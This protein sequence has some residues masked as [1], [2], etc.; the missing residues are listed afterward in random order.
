MTCSASSH[1]AGALLAAAAALVPA[2]EVGAQ[3]WRFAVSPYLWFPGTDVSVA[4]PQGDVD[5]SISVGDALSDLDFALMGTFEAQSWPWS[6]IGDLVYTDLTVREP[7]PFGVLFSRAD[8]RTRLG[9][10]TGYALYRAYDDGALALDVGAGLR[11]VF[12]DIDTRLRPA[13]A[14]DEVRSRERDEYVDPLLAARAIYQFDPNWFATASADIGGFASRRTATAQAFVSVGYRFDAAW[15]TQL[16][17]RYLR[18]ERESG[19]T[20][21]TTELS[22]PVLGL[23]YRF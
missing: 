6:L 14:P 8:V 12:L 15:S 23:T 3:D 21:T 17:Y 11:A 10:L 7:T 1:V 16:G 9:T 5:A 22:G 20:D 2:T 4:T 19:S 13:A 18:L